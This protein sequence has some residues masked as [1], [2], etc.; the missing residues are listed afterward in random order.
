M[1]RTISVLAFVGALGFSA[2]A[3]SQEYVRIDMEID[4]NRPAAEVWDK[5][6]GYCDIS[7]WFNGLD[8]EITSGDGGMGTVRALAGGRIV[9]ILVAQ[10]E[11]SYGYAQP[12]VEGRFYNLYHGQLEA[13][14]VTAGTSK[15]LYTL[16]YDVSNL[17]DQAAK[18]QDVA[19]RRGQF[20][21]ALATMK[22]IAES[23]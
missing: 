1:A 5:V 19:R 20:E 2:S 9:E 23:D 15:L 16:V 3:L 4:V 14:P 11:L 10:T 12:A 18:D 6:G 7:V 13:R 21:G 22:Q 8:C 17:A